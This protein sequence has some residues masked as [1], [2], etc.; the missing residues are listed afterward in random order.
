M[1]VVEATSRIFEDVFSALASDGYC[2]ERVHAPTSG[3]LS[4]AVAH[5]MDARP[6]AT[7]AVLV[8]SPDDWAGTIA[9]AAY[10]SVVNTPTL[11]IDDATAATVE[12]YLSI[13][14]PA[15]VNYSGKP[16]R[17]DG[18]PSACLCVR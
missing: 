13:R 3:D 18:A 7:D 10:G 15:A 16:Q 4:V 2:L 5:I 6:R 17:R 11:L 1:F 14:R 9:A 8:T 12:R